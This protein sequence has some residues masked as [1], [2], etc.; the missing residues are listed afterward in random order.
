MLILCLY[1]APVALLHLINLLDN[2]T[3]AQELGRGEMHNS[4]K[5]IYN[6]KMNFI[7]SEL[8]FKNETRKI[9]TRDIHNSKK[10]I[11]K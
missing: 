10:G 7:N 6:S 3:M 8:N 5:E 11:H 4:W 2:E 9:K 1:L